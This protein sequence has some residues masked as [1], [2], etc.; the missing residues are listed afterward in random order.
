MRNK[1][2]YLFDPTFKV[3]MHP[4]VES[5]SVK[6]PKK[7]TKC[8]KDMSAH[9]RKAMVKAIHKAWADGE[10]RTNPKQFLKIVMER[11][12][13]DETCEPEYQAPEEE[14]YGDFY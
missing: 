12:F 13:G 9:D 11:E 2:I 14:G 1:L 3:L 10:A 5:W 6:L 4:A 7:Q 8:L